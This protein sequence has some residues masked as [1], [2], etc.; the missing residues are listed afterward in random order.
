MAFDN[1]FIDELK[2]Q[3]D[4][5]DVV[6]RHVDLKR[7]GANYKGLCPFHSE[8]TPSFIVNEE[9]QIF[10]CFGCGEKGDVIKFVESYNKVPFMEAVE[11]LCKEY[12]IKMPEYS[13]NRKKVNYDKFYEINAKAGRFFYNELGV[14]GN[15]GLSYLYKR[16]IT[17]DT[18]T[19]WGLGFAPASGHALVDYLRAE[20]VEDK[21]MITLGL[22]AIGKSGELYDKFRNRVMFPIMNTQDNVIGFGGRAVEDIKPKYLNSNESDVFLKKNNLFGL[23]INKR[24]VSDQ[25]KII[26]VEG[27]MDV[28]SLWQNGVKNAVASLGTALTDNQAKLVSRYT[29]NV[30]LSYDSDNAG[31]A[32]ATRGIDIMSSAG[33]KAKVL[34]IADGKDPDEYINKYGKSSFE[35][36][37]E[38]AIPGTDFKLNIL[39]K[40]FD[41]SNDRGVLDYIERVVPILKSLSPVEQDIYIKKLAKEFNVSDHAILMAVQS[42]S[43]DAKNSKATSYRT[44]NRSEKDLADKYLKIELSFLILLIKNPK[45]INR[46]IED[47]IEFRTLLGQKIYNAIELFLKNNQVDSNG[48][49]EKLLF[50][51][52][53]PDDEKMLSKYLTN[54]VIGP[55][56]EEFYNQIY[57]NYILDKYKEKRIMLSN[58]LAVAEKMQQTEEMDKIANEILE[59]DSLIQKTTGGENA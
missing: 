57:K 50:Q 12:G 34:S 53:D 28:I 35:K 10:N 19:K 41:L 32:A 4:I 44:S 55:D 46:I 8:K 3:I 25:N 36:L 6:G 26:I 54:I 5:V 2:M 16:G 23:N 45:Y 21:D 37:I 14:K 58:D 33:I 7:T 42:E 29:K 18:I 24:D 13:Q 52:M 15:P 17:K 51:S 11:M 31:V 27:Y 22:A 43:S 1:N 30:V 20:K 59:I 38:E 39:K 47:K 40:E 48:I 9:K 49:E 56:D